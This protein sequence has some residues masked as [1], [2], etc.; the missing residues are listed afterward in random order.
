MVIRRM[1]RVPCLPVHDGRRFCV[2]APGGCPVPLNKIHGF[3]SV[4]I[5]SERVYSTVRRIER[6]A[7]GVGVYLEVWG[8]LLTP[9]EHSA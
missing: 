4:D 5:Q 8:V 1:G 7:Y 6:G 9:F 2:F 3:Q